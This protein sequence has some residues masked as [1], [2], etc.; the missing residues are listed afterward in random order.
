M[1][2]YR[3]AWVLPISEPPIRDGWIAIDRGRVIATGRRSANTSEA[4]I[5][6]GYVAVM[7]GLVNAHTHLE[8]SHMR[9]EVPPA[10]AFVSWI[11]GVMEARRK[12]PDPMST[13]ILDGIDIGIA[14]AIATGTAVVGD[15]SNTLATF[16]PLSRSPLA[17]V[18]FYELIRF[19]AADPQAVV[20]QAADAIAKLPATDR[21][22][23]SLAAHAPYSVAPLMFR[24]IREAVDRDPFAPTSVHLSESQEEVEFIRTGGGPWRALLE[25]IGSWDPKWVPP[26]GSPVQFLDDCGFLDGRV[27]AVHGVQMSG[28]D[29]ERL[30]KKDVTLVTC[31]RSNGHTG[32]GAPP[33]ADFYRSG[34]K[35]AVGTDSLASTPDLNVFAEVATMRALAP[36]VPAAAL[37][38]SATIVGARALGFDADYGTIDAGKRA[39]LLAVDIPIEVDDVE[40]YLVSGIEQR[41]VRWIDG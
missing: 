8:L 2:R 37:L 22:R 40:E 7:P 39:R 9:D 26:G 38:E 17:G 3:A 11:R 21:V 10:P 14:E 13:E 36:G 41:Q 27:L 1:I 19:N 16:A 25:A 30:A 29:L 32:A 6:L 24:A 23:A 20:E 15:I 12:R 34:V 5:D 4:E 31:P 18:V 28:A 33:I 35:V